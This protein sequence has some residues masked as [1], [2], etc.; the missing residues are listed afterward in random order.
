MPMIC[1]GRNHVIVRLPFATDTVVATYFP[2]PRGRYLLGTQPIA[3][4][5]AALRFALSMAEFMD[6]PITVHPAESAEALDYLHL[7]ADAHQFAFAGKT[8]EVRAAGRELLL[9]LDK[10]ENIRK[11]KGMPWERLQ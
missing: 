7:A 5:D 4:M 1:T 9:T 2:S 6:G 10:W 8:P 11:R 3:K